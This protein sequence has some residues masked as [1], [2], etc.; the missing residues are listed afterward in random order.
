MNSTGVLG[1]TAVNCEEVLERLLCVWHLSSSKSKLFEI[2]YEHTSKQR[3]R[4]LAELV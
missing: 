4:G 1:K 3:K 2:K